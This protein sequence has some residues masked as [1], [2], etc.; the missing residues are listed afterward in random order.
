MLSLTFWKFVKMTNACSQIQQD[1][2]AR[3]PQADKVREG[4]QQVRY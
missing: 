4:T 2:E 1:V 3:R